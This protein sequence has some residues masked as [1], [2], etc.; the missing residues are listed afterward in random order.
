MSLFVRSAPQRRDGGGYDIGEVLRRARG[1]HAGPGVD[2]GPERA[3]QHVAAY[4]ACNLI[5]SVAS[6]LPLDQ[7]RGQDSERRQVP[8][9]GWLDDPDGAGYGLEDWLYQLFDCALKRGNVVGR[10]TETDRLGRPSLVSI[11]HP[12][13]VTAKRRRES[14]EIEWTIERKPVPRDQVWHRRAYPIPGAIMGLSPVAHHARSIGL[15]LAAQ[16]FGAQYFADGGHPTAILTTD[17]PVGQAAARVVKERFLAA[18]RG[19]REPAVFGA[20]LKY[21][22]VQVR[23][24]ESQFLETQRYAAAD[25][26]R[27]WGPGVPEL[28]GYETHAGL[29]YTNIEGRSVDLLKYSFG[30]WFIRAERWLSQFTPPGEYLRFNRDAL[31]ATTTL[32]RFR[33]HALALQNQ[34]R[35]PNEVRALEELPA[36]AWGDEPLARSGS[37]PAEP[38]D[39]QTRPPTEAS[40]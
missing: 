35:N 22:A 10:I 36:A 4:A 12:D 8:R 11:A 3:T 7:F 27:I 25:V 17:K 33:V 13:A 32:E 37:A 21:Q 15:G 2:V 34:I 30:P 28:L 24:D 18:V 19:N 14:G 1:M 9:L 23:P 29:T 20:G 16:E 5:A 38:I 40:P 26:A 6:T 31:L 39:D